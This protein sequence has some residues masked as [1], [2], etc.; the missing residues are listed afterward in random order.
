MQ[1][2]AEEPEVVLKQQPESQVLP[3]QQGSP[4]PPQAAHRPLVVEV[5]L[6]TVPATQ[7]SVPLAPV[8]HGSPGL[9]QDEQVP[10]RQA[11]PELHVVDPQQG[12]PEPP[13]FAHLPALHIPPA[14]PP[15]PVALPQVCASATHISL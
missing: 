1:V 13:Q 10:L 3:L 5:L 14:V 8:Q 15:V 12:W 9:P 4:G 2:P 7:R 6:H 11:S